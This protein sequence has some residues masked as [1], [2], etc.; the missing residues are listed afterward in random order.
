[1][2]RYRFDRRGP[3]AIAAASLGQEFDAAPAPAVGQ[4]GPIGIV[5]I[6]GPLTHHSDGV[7]D[8]YDAIKSRVA[9]ALASQATC[10]V[11][12]IDSPG[13]DVSGCFEASSEIMA[14]AAAAGKPLYAYANGA[15]MSGAYVLACAAETLHVSQETLVGSIGVIAVTMDATEAD[16]Q[17]GL[18]FNIITSGARKADGNPHIP[19]SDEARAAI[20]AQTDS[21]AELFH[22]LVAERRGL[23][24]EEVRAFEADITNGQKAVDK[25]LADGVAT[26]SEFLALVASGGIGGSAAMNKETRVDYKELVAALRAL[27]EGDDE[28]QSKK[29]TAALVA[30]GEEEAPESEKKEDK[31]EGE[32]PDEKKKDEAQAAASA[33]TVSAA[34]TQAAASVAAENVE[35][36]QRIDRLEISALIEKRT[37]L[38]ASVRA[39]LLSV[40]VTTAKGFLA[41]AGKMTAPRNDKP[42]QG[43]MGPALLEG[44]DREDLD[45]GMGLRPASASAPTR[46]EDGSFIIH[47]ERPSEVRA[48]LAA[49]KGA[50]S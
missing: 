42:A 31:K 33:P 40:D 23:S 7:W 38:S 13:G 5:P 41:S 6:R 3:L 29:A 49:Q 35:L 30:M 15:V 22:G 32:Q 25:R 16:R 50:R 4:Q 47:V 10:V 21:F 26:M 34:S 19:L 1:M 43:K 24:I 2:K 20:Q 36:R 37:D 12:D 11:L 48:R 9:L 44:R 28:E 14:M 45:K 46:L 17:M 39:W 27:A 18:K 8:S